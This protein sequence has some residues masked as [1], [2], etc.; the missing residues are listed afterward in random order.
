MSRLLGQHVWLTGDE[1]DPFSMTVIAVNREATAAAGRLGTPVEVGGHRFSYA[2]FSSRHEGRSLDE[3]FTHPSAACN[4]TLIPDD[5]FR[6]D[7][8]LDTSWWR[9]GY[10][11]VGSV[12]LRG[13]MRR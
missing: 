9:G 12:S 6:E 4:V 5:R 10:A 7:D 3:V 2:A 11:F 13:S 1:H 8:P